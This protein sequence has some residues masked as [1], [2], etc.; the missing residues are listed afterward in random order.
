MRADRAGTKRSRPLPVPARRFLTLPRPAHCA[1]EI[2]FAM[3]VE[4]LAALHEKL[5]EAIHAADSLTA[6][7]GAGGKG[8]RQ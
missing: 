3:G 6:A 7:P 1:G 4:Q 5:K 8:S 2:R